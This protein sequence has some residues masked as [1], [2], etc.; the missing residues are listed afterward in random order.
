MKRSAVKQLLRIVLATTAVL[1]MTGCDEQ[2]SGFDL[3]ELTQAKEITVQDD[4]LMELS[5][6]DG[7]PC[8]TVTNQSQKTLEHGNAGSASLQANLEGTWYRVPMLPNWGV[9]AEGYTLAPG[10][11]YSGTIPWDA[12]GKLPDGDYRLAFE[13][14]PPHTCAVTEFSIE[15]GAVVYTLPAANSNNDKISHVEPFD[16]KTL[17]PTLT[18]SEAIRKHPEILDTYY[19][20]LLTDEEAQQM[21]SEGMRCFELDNDVSAVDILSSLSA[22]R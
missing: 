13:F 19:I 9:T 12:Y 17:D 15:D 16:L 14:F 18:L 1:S 3:S 8:L 10:Q 7:R 20:T 5:E 21:I 11:S 4:I 22:H 6:K 2:Q